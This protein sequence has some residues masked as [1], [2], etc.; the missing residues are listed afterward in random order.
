MDPVG[1]S[2]GLALWW[3]SE[4]VLNILYSS[5]SIIHVVVSFSSLQVT[6]Y[7]TFVYI[8]PNEQLQRGMWDKIL[9]ISRGIEGSWLCMGD[10]NDLMG[11]NEK[12]GSFHPEISKADFRLLLDG[13]RIQ[14][15]RFHMV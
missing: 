3:K 15:G 8:P 12:W 10:F 1:L 4:L 7:V 6:E 9:C 5:Q 13:P 14:G 2:G 11:K